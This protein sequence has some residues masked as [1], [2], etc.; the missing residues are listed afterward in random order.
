MEIPVTDYTICFTGDQIL[1]A[2]EYV[3]RKL[4]EGYN[5]WCLEINIE[6]M[7]Y[8]CVGGRQQDLILEDEQCIKYC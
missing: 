2:Q 6:K 1:L 3:T 7:E 5:K 8:M 4:I